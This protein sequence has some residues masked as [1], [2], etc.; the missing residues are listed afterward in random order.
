MS[1]INRTA[2]DGGLSPPYAIATHPELGEYAIHADGNG[3]WLFCDNETNTRRLF[4]SDSGPNYPK[5]AFHDFVVQGRQNAINPAQ[6]GTKAGILY[7]ATIPGGGSATFR[8]RLKH[9]SQS[10]GTQGKPFADFNSMFEARRNEADA[11]Y[12]ELQKDIADA[13]VRLVQRQAFAGMIWNK[14]FYYFDVPEWLRGDP[15]QPAPPAERRAG[16]NREW[17]HLNNADIISMPDKWEYPRRRLKC[18]PAS[19][20]W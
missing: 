8:L 11:F 16:R 19:R 18:K 1:L 2:G 9:C 20:C 12:A 13:D 17:S 6:T 15:G 14:Q 5:D 10:S 7:R 3:T 4:G